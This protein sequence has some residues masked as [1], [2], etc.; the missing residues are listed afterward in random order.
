M[1]LLASVWMVVGCSSSPASTEVVDAVAEVSA[2]AAVDTRPRADTAEAGDAGGCFTDESTEGCSS[3]C[4]VY[5]R[6]IDLAGKCDKGSKLLGCHA[7]A[8]FD[9]ITECAVEKST[10]RV[11]VFGAP[12]GF[13]RGA[14][15]SYRACTDQ[16]WKDAAEL[17]GIPCTP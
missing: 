11:F 17:V 7:F 15:P 8:A 4:L 16:E 12:Y 1:L 9:A 6:E 3:T 13:S 5:G 10:G 14:Y 2:D